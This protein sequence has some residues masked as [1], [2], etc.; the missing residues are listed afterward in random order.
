MPGSGRDGM[1]SIGSW[2]LRGENGAVTISLG[3]LTRPR[4]NPFWPLIEQDVADLVAQD[5][6]ARR[7]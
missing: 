2:L 4:S 7:R 3:S 6:A 5:L 1:P